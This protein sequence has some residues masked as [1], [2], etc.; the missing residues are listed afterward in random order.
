MKHHISWG[1]TTQGYN[2]DNQ[3]KENAFRN[4]WETVFKFTDKENREFDQDHEEEI[5]YH[6]RRNDR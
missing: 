1:I 2:Y 3:E 6:L 4:D 5:E